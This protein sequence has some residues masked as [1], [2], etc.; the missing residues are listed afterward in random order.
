MK[1][2]GK[3]CLRSKSGTRCARTRCTNT[4][5]TLIELMISIAIC[6][7]LSAIAIPQYSSFRNRAHVAVAISDI[8]NIGKAIILYNL[9][10]N[11]YPDT[12][13]DINMQN[14]LDPWDQP[15]VY[16]RIEGAANPGY[17]DLR[18]DHSLVPV[19]S[20]FDLYSIGPDGK[21]VA[22][23]TA[24]DSKDDIVRAN[25]GRYIGPVSNY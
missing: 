8:K 1:V 24:K 15:Y 23:F 25:N 13:A 22:P 2:C 5:Y 14:R 17:G 10:N 12:L 21:S 19:N 16:L 4:G 18:K 11:Q 20:D 6:G 7:T 9:D 3:K